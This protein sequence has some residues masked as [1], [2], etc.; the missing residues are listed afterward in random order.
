[1]TEPDFRALCAELLDWL[2]LTDNPPEEVINRARAVFA[3]WGRLAIEP[4][5]VSERLPGA[6]DCDAEGR[7]WC[8]NPV[9]SAGGIFWWSFEPL[10]Y[11]E[12]ATHWL[13]HWA[14]P[15]P[16]QEVK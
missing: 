14:L 7:C 5:P 9:T 3:R 2:R 15:V 11:V 1:M 6:E 8:F 16:Q 13:P 10:D 12:D 4:V